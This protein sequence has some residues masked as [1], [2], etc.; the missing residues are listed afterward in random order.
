MPKYKRID[1]IAILLLAS[2]FALILRIYAFS[3]QLSEWDLYDGAIGLWDGF[4]SGTGLDGKLQDN[5]SFS[6]GY[7]W[8]IYFLSNSADFVDSES[9]FALLNKLGFWSTTLCLPAI[10]LATGTAYG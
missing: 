1:W 5:K 7:I 3:T 10:W 9:L 6:F 2:F 4:Y 8:M